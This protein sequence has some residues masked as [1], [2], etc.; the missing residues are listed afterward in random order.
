MSKEMA[1]SVFPARRSLEKCGLTRLRAKKRRRRVPQ[2]LDHTQV[3]SIKVLEHL[4]VTHGSMDGLRLH[5][6]V[7]ARVGMHA[8]RKHFCTSDRTL[9]C[10]ESVSKRALARRVS[11]DFRIRGGLRVSK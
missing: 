6:A 9:A 7:H 4:C 1:F 3:F 2:H 8:S 10:C 11:R 5:R